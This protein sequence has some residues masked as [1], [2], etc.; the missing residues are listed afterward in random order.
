M[1][2][3]IYEQLCIRDVSTTSPNRFI[4][5]VIFREN[6]WIKRMLRNPKVSEKSEFKRL[7]KEPAVNHTQL[8]YHIHTGLGLLTRSTHRCRSILVSFVGNNG[9]TTSVL[10]PAVLSLDIC[11]LTIYSLC[12][13]V[14]SFSFWIRI[15][16]CQFDRL[17]RVT[18]TVCF[19]WT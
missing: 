14:K 16:S 18:L 7:W 2:P 15:A 11:H 9:L 12:S 6:R 4:A 8:W 19:I 5:R 1:P 10:P 3:Y 17:N 13:S